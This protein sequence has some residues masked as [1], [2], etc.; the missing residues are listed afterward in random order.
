MKGISL[1]RIV[2]YPLEYKRFFLGL[3]IASRNRAQACLSSKRI[4]S[5]RWTPKCD[6]RK[7]LRRRFP[8]ITMVKSADARESHE[9]GVR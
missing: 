4:R 9:L 1:P 5:S 8:E 6:C 7:T 3:E 2:A